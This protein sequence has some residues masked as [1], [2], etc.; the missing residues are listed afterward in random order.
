[1]HVLDLFSTHFWI[2]ILATLGAGDVWF[3]HNNTT[4]QNNSLVTLEDIGEND[5]ALLCITN[6]TACC[7]I[8]ST[9]VLG[10]WF[11]PNETNVPNKVVTN[12]TKWDFYRDRDQSVVRMK[13]RRGGK[14]GIYRCKIPDSTNVIQTI[15]IG[16]Y[17][18]IAGEWHCALLFQ[19]YA[20]VVTEVRKVKLKLGVCF[21]LHIH[22]MNNYTILTWSPWASLVTE[23]QGTNGLLYSVFAIG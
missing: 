23:L 7:R 6:L 8:T 11:F 18:A 21:V 9:S 22:V 12:E 15:Y 19:F 14:E 4:Y 10:Q 2:F 20:Y 1:M 3:S 16:V 17:T 5:T 13:R